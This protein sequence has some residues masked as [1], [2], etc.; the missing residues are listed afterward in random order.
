[1]VPTAITYDTTLPELAQRISQ[2]DAAESSEPI[3]EIQKI[4]TMH[5]GLLTDWALA[6]TQ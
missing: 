3:V 6:D 4:Q 1:M 5:D 2:I